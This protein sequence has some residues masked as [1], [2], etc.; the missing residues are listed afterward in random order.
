MSYIYKS[1]YI[2][3]TIPELF[4]NTATNVIGL[5]MTIFSLASIKK[6]LNYIIRK[7]YYTS[8]NQTT[9]ETTNKNQTKNF[10]Y[11]LESPKNYILDANFL[12]SVTYDSSPLIKCIDDFCKSNGVYDKDGIIVSLS[13]GVDSMVT[14]AI[15]LHLQK[16]HN[17][18]IYTASIDYGLREE[19]NDESN[20][21]IEYTKLFGIKSYVSYVKGVSRK[22][23]ESGSRSEFEEESRN[24]RFNTYKQIMQENN[25]SP[26]TGVF[27]AHHQDDIVENIFTNSMRGGNLLDL[28]VMKTTNTINDVKIMRPLIGFKKQVIYEFAHKFGVPYFLDT[29][30][31]W[32]KRGLM[33]NKIFPLLDSVFGVDWRNKLKQLGTQSNEW[34]EYVDKYVVKPW[35]DQIWKG[36]AGIVVPINQQPMLIYSQVIMK[37]LHSIGQTMLKKSSIEKINDLITNKHDK[38]VTL[39]GSRICALIDSKTKLIILDTS[40]VTES[41]E[42][43]SENQGLLTINMNYEKIIKG[44]YNKKMSIQSNIMKF[45]NKNNN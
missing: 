14:L 35:M 16:E 12:D 38:S 34:G 24:L 41:F 8:N 10:Q 1:H 5:F 11:L 45:L 43:M 25:L 30:P 39:D 21:L 33:R 42:P 17:F 36:P 44:S 6:Y 31:H 40:L 23:E 3:N 20:F 9:N 32:S 4:T 2:N 27:V 22:K 29:T 28:E 13:G 15:L 7:Y 26:D 18:K 37:S 19:S